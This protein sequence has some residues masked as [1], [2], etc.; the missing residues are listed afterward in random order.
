VAPWS[1]CRSDGF[2]RRGACRRKRVGQAQLAGYGCDGEFPLGVVDLVDADG[3]KSNRGGA[4]MA[5]QLDGGVP[6]VGID[7]LMGDNPVS[8]ED[9]SIRGVGIGRRWTRH[10]S[11]RQWR[12]PPGRRSRF[13]RDRC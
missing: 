7:E 11:G 9:L 13:C 2:N 1:F 12:G 3:S 4:L 8:I 6:I 10:S 5:E